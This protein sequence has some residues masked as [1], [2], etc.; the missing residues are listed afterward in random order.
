LGFLLNFSIVANYRHRS[1]TRER[2][3]LRFS[4]IHFRILTYCL[5]AP[6]VT[7]EALIDQIWG[8]V[9]DGGPENAANAADVHLWRL[10]N[11]GRCVYCVRS[12]GFAIEPDGRG[13]AD[14]KIYRVIDLW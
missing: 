13:G 4:P 5:I 7:L 6:Y 3:T 8:D 14:K 12:L 9:P 11:G 10:R 1:L 2:V